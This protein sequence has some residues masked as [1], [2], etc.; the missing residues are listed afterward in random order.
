[1]TIVDFKLRFETEKLEN[2][3]YLLKAVVH[4]TRLAIIDLLDQHI[5]MNVTELASVLDLSHALI[6]HHLTDMKSKNILQ[7]RRDGQQIFYSIKE[8][9][10]LGL[11]KCIQRCS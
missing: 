8:K 6:S 5:E 1:M 9:A 11:L 2:A 10:V 3:A 4:P 7:T